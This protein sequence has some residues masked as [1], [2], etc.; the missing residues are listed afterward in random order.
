[1]IGWMLFKLLHILQQLHLQQL[2]NVLNEMSE[3]KTYS[4]QDVVNKRKNNYI[5][6]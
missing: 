3:Q 4:L 1:M 5:G 2:Q 6:H